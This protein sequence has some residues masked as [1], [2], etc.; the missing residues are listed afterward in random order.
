MCLGLFLASEIEIA[1]ADDP[2]MS[3]QEVSGS[4]KSVER[5]FSLPQVRYIGAHGGC[6]C[7]FSH[8][9]AEVPIEWYD[10][11]FDENDGDVRRKDLA[12]GQ[13]LLA[14]ISAQLAKSAVVEIYPVWNGDEEQPCK[15]RIDLS[16]GELVPEKLFF[17][18]RFLHRIHA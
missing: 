13:R 12:S 7:G 15:G 16:L 4:E 10:G 9:S 8:G 2:E 17:N 5:F 11:F 1:L 3:V 18:E 6:S 14:L